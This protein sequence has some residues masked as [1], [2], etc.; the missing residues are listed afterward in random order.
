VSFNSDGSFDFD[1]NAAFESLG[2]I[3]GTSGLIPE[4]TTESFVYQIDDGRGGTD[5]A[6]ATLT[7]TGVN[8]AP[9]G[10][11]DGGTGFT[12]DENQVGPFTTGNVLSND[13]DVDIEPLSIF[14]FDA[15]TLGTIG[16]VSSNTD[17]SFSYEPGMAFNS[18]AAGT[19]ATD[20]FSYRATD[21]KGG[22]SADTTV[23][24]TITGVND[25]P[26]TMTD[27]G[28]L[29]DMAPDGSTVTIDV[30]ANDSDI[31]AGDS[32]DPA[33]VTVVSGPTTGTTAVNSTTGEI[34]YTYVD[35]FGFFGGDS[36]SYTVADRNGATSAT[37]TVSVLTNLPPSAI[38]DSA[39]VSAGATITIPVL[40]NDTDPEGDSLIVVSVGTSAGTTTINPDSTI[41]YT[42]PVGLTSDSFTY[43]IRDL[44]G[45]VSIASVSI[46][47]TP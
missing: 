9:V 19:T 3:V 43:T 38:F 2:V 29:A 32:P 26:T 39:T 36:F 8:D 11:A 22:I 4:T 34:T 17:G 24:M 15:I 35:P 7:I 31:D 45:N 33:T 1:P 41:S 37:T 12:L 13:T 6:T 5:T 44:V 40:D 14:S 42:A 28:Y 16:T 23:S 18:L 25:I 10:V 46:T 20:R 47:I 30:L 27:S 21:G